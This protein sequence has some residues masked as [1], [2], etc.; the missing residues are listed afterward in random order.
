MPILMRRV[1]ET[2]RIGDEVAV[3]ILSV[4]GHQVRTGIDAPQEIQGVKSWSIER[5]RARRWPEQ[6][7]LVL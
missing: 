7:C 6:G 2:L 4:K 1:G 3:T 5:R